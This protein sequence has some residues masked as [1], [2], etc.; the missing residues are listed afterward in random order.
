MTIFV[1]TGFFIGLYNEKD[2]Y[3]SKSLKIYQKF[4]EN[5]YGKIYTS[6][7]VINE[8]LTYLQR[9]KNMKFANYL[10]DLWIRQEKG[11]A[12]I[13]EVDYSQ[14][15]KTTELFIKQIN[16]RKP[17]SFTDCSNVILCEANSISKIASFD[18]QFKKYLNCI[19]E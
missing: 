9:K 17:L 16:E 11:F 4:K 8:L 5:H 6:T 19:H 14:F 18:M 3:H 15:K 12:K 1:D 2:K 7:Y 10:A 13:L